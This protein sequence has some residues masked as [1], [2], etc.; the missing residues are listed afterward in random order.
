M[1]EK[2]KTPVKNAEHK[3]SIDELILN[4]KSITGYSSDVAAGALF[5]C[6][7]KELSKKEFKNKIDEFLKKE[8][9]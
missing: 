3:Y 9:K 8:A 5:N 6:K 7:E 1:S 4:S 2:K